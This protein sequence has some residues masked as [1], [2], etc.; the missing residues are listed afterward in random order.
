MPRRSVGCR[1][2]LP[3]RLGVNDHVQV[4]G[5]FSWMPRHGSSLLACRPVGEHFHNN[6]ALIALPR[7]RTEVELI[8]DGLG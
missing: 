2:R 5:A 7:P 6:L 3:E 1:R 8:L 4:S